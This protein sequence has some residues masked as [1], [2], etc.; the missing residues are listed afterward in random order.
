MHP[1]IK[2]ESETVKTM[3]E[4]YCHDHHSFNGL[5][6]ECLSLIEYA[7]RRLEGCPFQEGKTTCAKC[8]VHCYS[9]DM[10]EKIRTIMRYS[11]PRM[12]YKHPTAALWHLVD[13][14]RKEPIKHL[15]E[16]RKNKATNR[17]IHEDSC[18]N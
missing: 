9:P 7:Q 18:I 1:R 14:R 2:R 13:K 10:R 3:I 4:L 16:K 12:L 17:G 8:P 11:G 5:C 15:S 6:L